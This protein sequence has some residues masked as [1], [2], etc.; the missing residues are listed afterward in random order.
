MLH[1]AGRAGHG[2]TWDDDEN[3]DP[4]QFSLVP[5]T[6]ISPNSLTNGEMMLFVFLALETLT[7]H[8]WLLAKI[9][10]EES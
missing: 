4:F 2:L 1:R 6:V 8:D 9:K 5:R 7:G 3:C 10:E